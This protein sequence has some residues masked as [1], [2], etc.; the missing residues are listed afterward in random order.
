[1]KSVN[2]LPETIFRPWEGFNEKDSRLLVPCS[3]AGKNLESYKKI[4]IKHV[5]NVASSGN[6]LSLYRKCQNDNSLE[7]LNQPKKCKNK[8]SETSPRGSDH[9]EAKSHTYS[10]TAIKVKNNI[11]LH[12]RPNGD[13][14]IRHLRDSRSIP[15]AKPLT[16][17]MKCSSH[18]AVKFKRHTQF[19]HKRTDTIRPKDKICSV[20]GNGFS[21]KGQLDAH[22]R[23]HTGERPFAC[24]Y[25]ID[26]ALNKKC[27]KRFARNEE[28]TRHHRT[29]TGEKPHHC[30]CGKAFGRRDHL[31]KHMK[32][33]EKEAFQQQQVVFQEELRRRRLLGEAH[34]KQFFQTTPIQFPTLETLSP[35]L[36]SAV[37][38]H[39]LYS[40]RAP[41][42][43]TPP[44]LRPPLLSTTSTSL[45]G[46]PLLPS[47]RLP[48]LSCG[49]SHQMPSLS[50]L[51]PQSVPALQIKTDFASKHHM[52]NNG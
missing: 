37:I 33:H 22:M 25:V 34:S 14:K 3:V 35:S 2:L 27:E 48:Q 8:L 6:E 41:Q 43:P 50:L 18:S 23:V 10:K 49:S 7:F 38:D 40:Q 16:T 36:S 12:S 31:Q 28:L 5:N 26:K 1:M 24:N 44:P 15:T 21:N 19:S 11:F 47:S 30:Y 4:N 9:L 45:L 20:C 42:Y 29:H 17:I 51:P 39:L 52:A 46:L 13:G 32:R